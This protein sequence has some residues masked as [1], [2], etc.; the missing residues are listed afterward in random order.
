MSIYENNLIALSAV[1]K[2]LADK[3]KSITTNENYE[4]FVTD[5]EYLSDLNIVD[6]RDATTIDNSTDSINNK[7]KEFEKFDNYYS[8]YFFGIGSGVF[9]EKL[10]TN[11]I[12]KKIYIFEPELELVY[13]V[14]NLIDFS[15]DI[16]ERR[17]IIK[18]SADINLFKVKQLID[19]QSAL[20]V[21]K[22]NLDIYS[23]YYDKYFDEIKKV[24]D[25]ILLYF[26]HYLQD[27]GDSLED[28]LIG[29]KH[30]S[31]RMLEMFK[32]PSMFRVLESLKNRK[33]AIMV[34]TGPSLEKQLPILKKYKD[35]LTI[36]CVD[37]SFPVLYKEGIKP[38]I[39]LAMER[40]PEVAN[41]FKDVPAEFHKDVIFMLATVCHDEAF[42]SIKEGG[43]VCPYLRADEHNMNLGL[44][45]WGY[46]GGG[47]S[48]A[49]Y[50]FNFA[51]L[52]NF[53]N[54]VFIGQ[55]LAFAKDGSSH[56]KGH[57]FGT[58]GNK[59]DEEF[60]GYLPAYG[61]N[62]KVATQKYWRLF[63]NDFVV[64][65]ELSKKVTNM[66][67]YNATEGGARISNA[68][69]IPFKTFCEDILDTKVKKT[70]LDVKYPLKTQVQ[71]TTSKYIAKQKEN[72]KLAKSVRKYAKKSFNLVE[73]F[74]DRIKEFNN[75]EL[76]QN[77]KDKELDELLNKIYIVKGKY[78][79][80]AF[81][82]NFSSLFM[83]YLQHVEFDIAAAKTMRENTSEA[84]KLKKINYIKVHYEW[85]FRLWGS[86]DKIIEILE[87]SISSKNPYI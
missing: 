31:N 19:S 23:N 59:I 51:A 44:E 64:A 45:K 46:L 66:Q 29:F 57:V 77:V 32:H 81:I 16:L 18:P 30:S 2:D 78:S 14:L 22:Y 61:G 15:K 20:Y 69:E 80:P 52:A 85:L 36:L 35:Y 3:L 11:T 79:N 49:N 38:D 27:R 24:N 21:K 42:D 26:K 53:E 6:N 63:L 10:L 41:F 58:D 39:V 67:V 33:H 72:L 73:L 50:L 82:H 17:L 75:E 71:K 62:G 54:F 47:L 87:D 65:I 86:L 8:L 5:V 13:V 56:A 34:S 4:V 28:T 1:D 43:I 37:A 9:Y 48:G 84:I 40:V 60:D 55:D 25:A 74:L 12:H 70:Q 83:S 7:L 76:I 68:V